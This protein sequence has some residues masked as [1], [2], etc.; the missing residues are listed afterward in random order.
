MPKELPFKMEKMAV[1]ELTRN[2]Q[3][4]SIRT[5]AYLAHYDLEVASPAASL[6]R[7]HHS[8]V[9]QTSAANLS[10]QLASVFTTECSARG[11]ETAMGAITLITLQWSVSLRLQRCR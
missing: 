3:D 7:S 2:G 10:L 5:T 8:L 9:G 4:D 6:L 11:H 1:E